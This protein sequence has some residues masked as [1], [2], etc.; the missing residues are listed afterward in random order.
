MNRA[1]LAQTHRPRDRHVIACA[2]LIG[3]GVWQVERLAWKENLIAQVSA[4]M[5]AAPVAA[6]GPVSW[7]TLDIDALEYQPVTVSGKFDN[8]HEAHVIYTLTSPKGPVGGVGYEVMTP[9]TTDAGWT[10]YV[11]RGFVPNEKRDPATR[12]AGQIE[13]ETAVTG[14]CAARPTAPGSCPATT[15][16]RTNGSRAIPR[17]SPPPRRSRRR[18]R[19]SST[20]TT[21]RLCRAVFRKA[22]ETIVDFPNSHLGLRDYVVRAG[23]VLRGRVHRVRRWKAASARKLT[24]RDPPPE[25]ASRFR[26]PPQ[27]GGRSVRRRRRTQ[28]PLSLPLAGRVAGEAG[29]VGD[30][31]RWRYA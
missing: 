24:K 22:G 29:R 6:P 15:S 14:F 31:L 23:G 26:P 5:T 11:N 3:L 25:I 4:R 28:T 9:L 20:R 30:R 12:A 18:R 17:C 21:I 19:I 1:R 7:P 13:G 10:V 2:I 16:P 8:A 27:G